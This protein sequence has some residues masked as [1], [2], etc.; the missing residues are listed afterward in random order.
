MEYVLQVFSGKLLLNS[1]S[2]VINQSSYRNEWELWFVHFVVVVVAVVVVV[3]VVFKATTTTSTPWTVAKEFFTS[4]GCF[5]AFWC[6][7][8]LFERKQWL[9]L[10]NQAWNFLVLYCWL[11]D[12][13]IVT[14]ANFS[15]VDRGCVPPT[16]IPWSSR[17]AVRRR[18]EIQRRICRGRSSRRPLW[19]WARP[20]TSR[21]RPGQSDSCSGRTSGGR[22]SPAKTK[23]IKFYKKVKLQIYL[24]LKR[25]GEKT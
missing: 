4:V 2:W 16:R 22:S 24:N 11:N 19:P 21:R 1:F 9:F 15:L 17:Q 25:F 13:W 7:F 14:C 8:G 5:F 18:W 20:G 6:K 23:K 12:H 10:A 3:V